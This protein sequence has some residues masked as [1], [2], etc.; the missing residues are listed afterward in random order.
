MKKR[1]GTFKIWSTKYR[2]RQRK[3][4]TKA[5]SKF[6]NQVANDIDGMTSLSAR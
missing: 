3:K 4:Q 2:P 6:S 5:S 1:S